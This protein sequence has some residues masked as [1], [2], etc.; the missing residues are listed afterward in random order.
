M[1]PEMNFIARIIE[2]SRDE[3]FIHPLETIFELF[4]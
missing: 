3:N 2:N 4:I 1:S